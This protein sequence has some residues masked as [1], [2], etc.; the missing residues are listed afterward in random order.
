[1]SRQR[2]R[3]AFEE[4]KK[5]LLPVYQASKS[6]DFPGFLIV[7]CPRADCIGTVH[8]R[9]FIVHGWTWLRPDR[10]RVDRTGKAIL[11]TGR[12]CPYCFRVGRLPRRSDI[13]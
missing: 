10:L 8:D 7:M 6:K 1:M 9:P 4:P 2:D 5:D 3:D 11:I 12:S 13:K